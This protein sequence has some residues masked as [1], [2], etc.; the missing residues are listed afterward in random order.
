MPDFSKKFQSN[1]LKMD[2]SVH[3]GD[4]ITFQSAG[5]DEGT[6]D[7]PKVIFDVTVGTD[8]KTFKFQMN[9]TN[10]RETSK[11]YGVNTDAWVGKTME[12]IRTSNRNPRTGERVP[13]IELVAPGKEGI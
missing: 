8:V 11:L 12:V 6:V 4:T 9:R 1:W 5:N 13:S 2:E 10:Y 3:H 7:D